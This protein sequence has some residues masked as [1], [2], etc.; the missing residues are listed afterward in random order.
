MVT[1][2]VGVHEQRTIPVAASIGQAIWV[3]TVVVPS[4]SLR[5][6]APP[7]QPIR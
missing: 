7:Y 1:E 4:V 3:E 2:K 5:A 6:P